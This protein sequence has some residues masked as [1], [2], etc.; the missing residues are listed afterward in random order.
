MKGFVKVERLGA[1]D[2]AESRGQGPPQAMKGDAV[3]MREI[4]NG[5]FGEPPQ[6]HYPEL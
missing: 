3:A 4:L 6:A 1:S 5:L 2:R